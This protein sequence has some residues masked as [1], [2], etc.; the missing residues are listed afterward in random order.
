MEKVLLNLFKFG[1][2]RAYLA[3]QRKIGIIPLLK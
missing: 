1:A 3:Q 2:P